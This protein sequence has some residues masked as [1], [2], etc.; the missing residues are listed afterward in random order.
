MQFQPTEDQQAFRDTAVRF[1]RERLADSYLTRAAG[2]TM[3]RALL[4][5]DAALQAHGGSGFTE[6]SGLYELYRWSVCCARRPS[7]AS[8]A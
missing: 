1:A 5:D 3:D 8:C 2:H 7:T 6:D 4:R